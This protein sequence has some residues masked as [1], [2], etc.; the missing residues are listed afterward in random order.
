MRCKAGTSRVVGLEV[1]LEVGLGMGSQSVAI[2]RHK[3]AVADAEVVDMTIGGDAWD[4]AA[5][6]SV[7]VATSKTREVLHSLV[8]P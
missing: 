8:W 5:G 4:I 3:E 7:V 1:V 2:G 6:G